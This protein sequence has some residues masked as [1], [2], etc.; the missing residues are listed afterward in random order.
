MMWIHYWI[1][2]SLLHR[3]NDI[4]ILIFK[5]SFSNINCHKMSREQILT[6]LNI[7]EEMVDEF[8]NSTDQIDPQIH[9]E[10]VNALEERWIHIQEMIDELSEVEPMDT[11]SMDE[12]LP[13]KIHRVNSTEN[14]KHVHWDINPK[15][16]KRTSS[17]DKLSKKKHKRFTMS[18]FKIKKYR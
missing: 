1:T 15:E 14:Q 16:L 2:Y 12:Y 6:Q 3:K 13:Q 17:G 8:E 7:L 18:F 9:D 10:T 5:D 4:K 11:V